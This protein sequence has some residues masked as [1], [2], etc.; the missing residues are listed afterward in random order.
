[1]TLAGACGMSK[2]WHFNARARDQEDLRL[3]HW[4]YS[5]PHYAT[6]GRALQPP[7]LTASRRRRTTAHLPL[8]FGMPSLAY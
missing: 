8:A 1:M 6:A 7:L 5:L 2:R 4:A 3:D